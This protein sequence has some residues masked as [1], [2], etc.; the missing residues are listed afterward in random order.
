MSLLQLPGFTGACA[1]ENKSPLAG[2]SPIARKF[3][4]AS[5]TRVLGF[6]ATTRGGMQPGHWSASKV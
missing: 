4:A 5:A 2:N 1:V 6:I 3:R